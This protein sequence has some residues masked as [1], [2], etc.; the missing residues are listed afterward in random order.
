MVNF[1]FICWNLKIR[2]CSAVSYEPESVTWTLQAYGRVDVDLGVKYSNLIDKDGARTIL[3]GCLKESSE[4]SG[5]NE[6][7]TS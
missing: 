4:G 1:L 2:D 5:G 7:I 6:F 3:L